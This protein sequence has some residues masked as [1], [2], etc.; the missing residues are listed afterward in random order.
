[1]ANKHRR[2]GDAAL[3]MALA[4][5]E[6]VEVA[7]RQAGVSSRT[8]HRRL[9]E[10]DF[11]KLIAEARVTLVRRVAGQLAGAGDEAVATMR[12]LLSDEDPRVRLGAAK[13]VLEYLFK[14]AEI[15]DLAEKLV[16]VEARLD[17]LL[18]TERQAGY[19]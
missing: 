11:R 16:E 12:T 18:R 17:E 2:N 19:Q 15:G 13:G 10:E 4:R 8:A 14:A 3:A 6:P 5:G 1:M 7:A 9:A